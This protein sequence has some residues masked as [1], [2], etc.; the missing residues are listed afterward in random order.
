MGPLDTAKR[1]KD[2][3]AVS[4]GRADKTEVVGGPEGA[5]RSSS[6]RCTE[7]KSPEDVL[8]TA[9]SIGESFEDLGG[10]GRSENIHGDRGWIGKASNVIR[11]NGGAHKSYDLDA[12]SDLG[13]PGHIRASRL[14]GSVQNARC[15]FLIPMATL[16]WICQLHTK[17]V[18]RLWKLQ[19]VPE[20]FHLTV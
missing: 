7:P 8:R 6:F 2:K 11:G 10:W 18:R 17:C 15:R 14:V 5:T 12:I 1:G 16:A 20:E 9:V 3:P 13:T 4:R 19:H